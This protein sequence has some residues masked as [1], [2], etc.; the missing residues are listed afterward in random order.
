MV[1]KLSAIAEAILRRTGLHPPI[2]P[3][4]AARAADL[5]IAPMTGMPAPA[6]LRCG[7]A[8]C[9]DEELPGWREAVAD[10]VCGCL[11]RQHGL[12]D[13]KFGRSALANLLGM[14]MRGESSVLDAVA[15]ECRSGSS[16]YRQ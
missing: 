16:L 14:P 2:H 7:I 8:V 5:L 9:F 15:V 12:P 11:L 13:D 4:F 1:G 3:L 6:E 10:I